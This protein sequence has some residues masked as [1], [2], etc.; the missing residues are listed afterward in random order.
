MVVSGMPHPKEDRNPCACT[1]I[2]KL[3]L[4]YTLST[5]GMFMATGLKRTSSDFFIS[6]EAVETAANTYTQVEITLPLNALDRE[7][8]V[9]TGILMDPAT[10]V[11]IAL[12]QTS[13][14]LQLT[15]NSTAAMQ[16]LA[17]FN[18]ISTSTESINGGVG[19]FDF[20][21]KSYG[22]QITESGQDHVDIVATPNMFLAVQGG[23]NT[24]PL[25]SS[26]RV[27]GYRAKADVSV[28]SALIASELNA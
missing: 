17:D 7:V 28:Y 23:N 12:T 8:F 19:E 2:M 1:V 16:T 27:Y 13:S 11:S 20:F 21:S 10:P 18:L 3:G 6:A 5:V 22:N 4:L 25:T 26:I 14:Q 15:R 9:I 24:G